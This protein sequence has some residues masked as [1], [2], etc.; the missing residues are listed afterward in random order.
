MYQ[1]LEI[2]GLNRHA[3]CEF[4]GFCLPFLDNANYL[5]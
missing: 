5:R 1:D 4:H 2:L 3:S